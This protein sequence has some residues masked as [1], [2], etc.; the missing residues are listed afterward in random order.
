MERDLPCHNRPPVHI[1]LLIHN[2]SS[3]AGQTRYWDTSDSESA[4]LKNIQ[5]PKK[6]KQ[7]QDLGYV[8]VKIEYKFNQDGFRTPELNQPFDIVCFGCSFTM[9]TGVHTW[10]TW[11]GQLQ[12]L[13]GMTVANL[14]H[15]G[16]SNDT[17]F[18]FANYYL[19]RLKPQ[20]AVWLQT[21]NHRLELLNDH[22]PLSQNIIASDSNKWYA[23]DNFIKTW[24][25]SSSNQVLNFQKNTLAFKQLC[26]E[27]NIQY[28]ILPSS[29]IHKISH[30]QSDCARDLLHPGKKS[31]EL[32][33]YHVKKT[34]FG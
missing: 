14:G 30:A 21:D 31:Y 16:S 6:Q 22:I 8:D 27:L 23:S 7:L 2:Y 17:A 19:S 12:K 24:F 18:R 1:I 34:L 28:L 20:Y 13:S 9:G 33:A 25:S 11:P 32:L 26:N 29:Q 15:A 10:D 5:C 4:Y 3:V